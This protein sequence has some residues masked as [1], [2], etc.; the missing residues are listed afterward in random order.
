MRIYF[1]VFEWV[2]WGIFRFFPIIY[3]SLKSE[4]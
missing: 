3:F 2:E 4:N 1:T